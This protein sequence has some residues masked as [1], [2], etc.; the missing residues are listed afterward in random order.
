MSGWQGA[1]KQQLNSNMS[2][3]F[4]EFTNSQ[5]EDLARYFR[6]YEAD[7]Q[8]LY[9]SNMAAKML[10][11]AIQNEFPFL[12]AMKQLF[13]ERFERVLNEFVDTLKEEESL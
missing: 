5:A 2:E 11:S 3:V 8:R 6:A 4:K 7:H 9:V 13:R 12:F 1:T 10:A